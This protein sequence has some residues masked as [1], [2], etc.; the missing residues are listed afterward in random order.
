M[1]TIVL[2]C[3]SCCLIQF[4][5]SFLGPVAYIHKAEESCSK[6]KEISF[7]DAERARVLFLCCWKKIQ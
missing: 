4:I 3:T 5:S 7:V 6:L 2:F 1:C